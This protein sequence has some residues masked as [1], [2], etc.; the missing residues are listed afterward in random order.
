MQKAK[1]V[2]MMH[3]EQAQILKTVMGILISHEVPY[4]YQHLAKDNSSYFLLIHNK[5][6]NSTFTLDTWKEGVEYILTLLATWNDGMAHDHKEQKNGKGLLG[7][8]I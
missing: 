5:D 7:F 8:T 2:E 6:N 3:L 4:M 1:G